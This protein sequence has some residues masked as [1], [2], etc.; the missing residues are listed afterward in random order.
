[1][2]DNTIIVF[3]AYEP[4]ELRKYLKRN[5]IDPSWFERYLDKIPIT[6]GLMEVEALRIKDNSVY[7]WASANFYIKDGFKCIKDIRQ[8]V[9]IGD[10]E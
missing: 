3:D 5:K 8:R 9:Y 10:I 6:I 7:S 2:K 4:K 1:M